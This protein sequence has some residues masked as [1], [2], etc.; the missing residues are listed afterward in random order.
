MP[1]DPALISPSTKGR[2]ERQHMFAPG[3][4]EPTPPR[5][6]V[7]PHGIF[8]ALMFAWLVVFWTT[9]LYL[10]APVLQSW[11]HPHQA[12]SVPACVMPTGP[13]Q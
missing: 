12:E 7:T 9:A 6:K 5:R 8:W 13:A 1:T 4:I 10:F 3:V 2:L 11:L